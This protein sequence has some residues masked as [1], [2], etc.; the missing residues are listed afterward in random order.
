MT[1]SM[2]MKSVDASELA[3]IEGGA[4]PIVGFLIGCAL[5]VSAISNL[6]HGPRH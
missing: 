6:V 2:M 4:F 3:E 1:D 5:L